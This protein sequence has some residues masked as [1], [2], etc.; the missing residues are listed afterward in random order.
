[1][2]FVK[3]IYHIQF[4][5]A[6]L[7]LMKKLEIHE[8]VDCQR[9]S[10]EDIDGKHFGDKIWPGMDCI[11]SAPV[12]DEKAEELFKAIIEFKNEDPRRKHIRILILP[13]EKA[14]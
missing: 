5:E 10:A 1:M 9:I 6:I 2:K 7:D 12:S 3:I 11:L 14:G 4:N 13:I 8:Y